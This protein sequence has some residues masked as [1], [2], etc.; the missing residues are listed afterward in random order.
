MSDRYRRLQFGVFL[1]TLGVAFAVSGL[2]LWFILY[3]TRA[4]AINQLVL[5]IVVH[6]LFGYIVVMSGI[7]IY[8]SDLSG[9]ECM[10]ATKQSL[11]GAGLMGALVVWRALPDLRSGV[12]TLEFLNQLVVVSSVGAAAGVLVGLNRS[13]AMRNRRLAVEKDG[14][15]ETL[16]FLLRLLDHDIQNHLTAISSYTSTI[17]PS[18][19]DSRADP[20]EGIQDRTRDIER[21]LETA[22]A[23][24]ES[25][26]GNQEFER[27]D[28]AAVLREQ[29]DVFRAET[30][31]VDIKTDIDGDLYVES[32]R[33]IGD[34][35]HNILDNAVTHNETDDLTVAVLAQKMDDGIVV[36]IADD[37]SGI[38]DSI[39]SDI[40]D[41]GVRADGSDGD[42]IGLYLVRKLVESYGGHV[43]VQNRSPSGTR[44]RLWLPE[45]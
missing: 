13:Q 16:V 10:L 28:I 24:L 21:L 11:I 12:V 9:S 4:T 33:F 36:D 32:N 15:E 41:P 39:R 17:D 3:R 8:Q 43:A 29:L 22:N 35:F 18:A 6:V 23:V 45:G 34:V 27:I 25:E 19:V 2:L 44:F 37:G 14:R 42:G 20:I 31:R 30:P 40:F 1:G 38:A 7:N 26:T 5:G